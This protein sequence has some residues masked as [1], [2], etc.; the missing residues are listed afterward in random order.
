M[1]LVEVTCGDRGSD[2]AI[3]RRGAVVAGFYTGLVLERLPM[4]I[5]HK[6]CTK[7][8]LTVNHVTKS[9]H[10]TRLRNIWFAQLTSSLTCTFKR[11]SIISLLLP[12]VT[13]R[14]GSIPACP[15][16]ILSTRITMCIAIQIIKWKPDPAPRS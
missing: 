6:P 8:C 16:T 13:H 4:S 15:L 10:A 9:Y 3:E 14:S 11:I 7:C 1:L 2:G 5:L 12:S